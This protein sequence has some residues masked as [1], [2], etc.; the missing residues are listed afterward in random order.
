M[1]N[2]MHD[3]AYQGK[4]RGKNKNVRLIVFVLTGSKEVSLT[5][6]RADLRVCIHTWVMEL[7]Y[8]YGVSHSLTI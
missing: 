6:F 4:K 2:N 3:L 5:I 7:V 8:V 1:N